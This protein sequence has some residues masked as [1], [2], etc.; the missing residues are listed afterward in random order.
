M[1]AVIDA[2]NTVTDIVT[3]VTNLI[4]DILGRFGVLLFIAGFFGILF[5]FLWFIFR[6][7]DKRRLTLPAIAFTLFFIIFLSGNI[8]MIAQD[9]RTKDAE[10]AQL[11]TA[12]EEMESSA[13]ESVV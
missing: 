3:G 4:M 7:I 10:A 13:G 2:L 6:Y 8:L 5:T 12:G 1:A 11:E 9:A